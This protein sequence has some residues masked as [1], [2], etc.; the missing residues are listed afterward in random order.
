MRLIVM[1]DLPVVTER[2]KKIYTKFRRFLLDDGYFMLQYSVYARICK[3]ADDVKKHEIK[4]SINMPQNGNVRLLQV[5]E[6]QFE[7]MRVL[8][9]KKSNE[10]K[11]GIEPLVIFE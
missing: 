11:V 4:L 9:G 1:F 8:C 10:E 6:K 3:N 5:T 2:D 7:N